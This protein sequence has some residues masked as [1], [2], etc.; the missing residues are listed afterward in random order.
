MERGFQPP[1]TELV[2][3]HSARCVPATTGL[4]W[5]NSDTEWLRKGIS[6][7]KVVPGKPLFLPPKHA[8]FHWAARSFTGQNC[9]T[10]LEAEETND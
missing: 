3:H 5:T 7:G 6:A 1:V 4:S 8:V 2:V 10:S 9:A